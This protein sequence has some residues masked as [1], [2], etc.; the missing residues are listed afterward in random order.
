LAGTVTLNQAFHSTYVK[1]A[2]SSPTVP[3]LVS[4]I[5][6]KITN[7]LIIVKPS[8]V[9]RA[10]NES[11]KSQREREMEEI[12][13]EAQR[14]LA[15]RVQRSSEDIEQARI[16]SLQETADKNNCN[17]VTG[18]C[19]SWEKD[20]ADRES[21][22]RGVAF[23]ITETEHYAEVKTQGYISNTNLLIVHNDAPATEIIGSGGGGSNIVII[24]QSTGVLKR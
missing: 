1:S 5:E 20:G 10:I 2:S 11:G 17:Y 16:L 21:R 24:K 9:A 22:G 4:T 18:I 7:N 23:R 12:E 14:S 8:E 19:I 13:A 6:S 15:Q 3:T